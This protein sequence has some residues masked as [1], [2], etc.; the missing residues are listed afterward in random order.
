MKM[1]EQLKIEYW[2]HFR[3]MGVKDAS[4]LNEEIENQDNQYCEC[5]TEDECLRNRTE[6]LRAIK[7]MEE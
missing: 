3:S 5:A 7:E 2:K 4:E 1:L 6:L